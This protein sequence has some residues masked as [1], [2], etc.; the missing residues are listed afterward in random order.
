MA[1]KAIVNLMMP[2]F[3]QMWANLSEEIFSNCFSYDFE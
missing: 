3:L 2:I 1:V